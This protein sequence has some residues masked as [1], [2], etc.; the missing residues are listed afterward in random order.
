MQWFFWTEHLCASPNVATK[1]FGWD[2]HLAQSQDVA[3]LVCL[4]RKPLPV[5][6][7]DSW[8]S[9]SF[10][11]TI[12]RPPK[13]ICLSRWSQSTYVHGNL[14]SLITSERLNHIIC[15]VRVFNQI[16]DLRN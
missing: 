6:S 13:Y 11:H 16:I 2:E 8:V 1:G 3:N 12:I 15:I 14:N 9:L 7:G 10:A 5:G 4:G